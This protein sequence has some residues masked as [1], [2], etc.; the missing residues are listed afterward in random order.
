MGDGGAVGNG[1]A[2]ATVEGCVARLWLVLAQE[3][4]GIRLVGMA[5]AGKV[6]RKG[7]DDQEA[8]MVSGPGSL[9][10]GVIDLRSMAIT[11]I[12]GEVIPLCRRLGSRVAAL[13]A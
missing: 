8:D 9:I 2:E 3:E 1:D 10:P 5:A 7:D 11:V 13:G 6:G 4:G 12:S